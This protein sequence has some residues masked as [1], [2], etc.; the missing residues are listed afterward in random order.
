[1]A[2][3]DRGIAT[4]LGLVG[5]VLFGF[6]GFLDLLRGVIYLAVGHGVRAF[7]PWDEALLLIVVAIL[8]ALFS[9]LGGSRR[10]DRALLAGVVLVVIAIVGWL[11]LGFG[12]GV[13]ALLGSVFVLLGGVVFLVAAR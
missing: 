3:T 5:A 12:T 11:A 13:L 4:V 1:M 9:V 6:E 7:G 10:S 2:E 8:V